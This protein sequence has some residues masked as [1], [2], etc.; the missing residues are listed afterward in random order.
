MRFRF[1]VIAATA[2]CAIAAGFAADAPAGAPS[3]RKTEA[4]VPSNYVLRAGDMLRI[5]VF[6]EPDLDRELRI[7]QDGTVVLP[8]IKTINAAGMTVPQFGAEIARLYDADYLVNPQINI[9]VLQ[10]ADRHVNVM[11][12]V[13]APG[14]V[15]FPP[16]EKMTLLD[17]ITRAGGFNR[18]ADRRRVRLSRN[19]PGGEKLNFEINTDAVLKGTSSE[20]WLLQTDDVIFV[21]E[22]R[23]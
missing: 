3:A 6:Q 13:N 21:P 15:G 17:A 23:T 12:A 8:L 18:L 10:Y 19:G 11:G 22:S 5:Q 14:A 16:E 9:T 4:S 1:L 7:A 20:T 2:L